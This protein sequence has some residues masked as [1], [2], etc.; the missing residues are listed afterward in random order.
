M[1]H[2]AV[3]AA[4]RGGVSGSA[5]FSPVPEKRRTTPIAIARLLY[6]R[7]GPPGTVS[8]PYP[9]RRGVSELFSR[10]EGYFARSFLVVTPRRKGGGGKGGGVECVSCHE[11]RD[12]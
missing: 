7:G 1:A 6:R 4:I 8:N 12:G 3:A 10:S 5:S 9:W 2:P 11:D